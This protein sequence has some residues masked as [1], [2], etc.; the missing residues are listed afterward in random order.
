MDFHSGHVGQDNPGGEQGKRRIR[1]HELAE[2]FAI[3]SGYY[4]QFTAIYWTCP[5]PRPIRVV[6]PPWRHV[7]ERTTPGQRSSPP[8]VTVAPFFRPRSD[9]RG[10][11]AQW[12]TGAGTRYDGPKST[13]WLD[14]KETAH[15]PS[16]RN[17]HRQGGRAPGAIQ[18][19]C[20]ND[21]L[22]RRV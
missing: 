3:V 14:G 6:V 15:G 20:R 2:K 19:Q 1:P 8:K 12:R 13:N 16:L 22:H 18:V 10:C 9:I 17:L 21:L 11:V 5:P 7:W 4:A